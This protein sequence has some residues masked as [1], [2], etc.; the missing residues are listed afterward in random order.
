MTTRILL[1]ATCLLASACVNEFDPRCTLEQGPSLPG[2][3]FTA[4]NAKFEDVFRSRD[5]AGRWV[6]RVGN[7]GFNPA[8]D[9]YLPL[10]TTKNGTLTF[11]SEDTGE[12]DQT[13]AW[14]DSFSLPPQSTPG[15]DSTDS[16]GTAAITTEGSLP[17]DHAAGEATIEV[18]FDP[19]L[20]LA[21]NGGTTTLS[22]KL[23]VKVKAGGG[24][25]VGG[26]TDPGPTCS[27]LLDEV[28]ARD[29]SQVDGLPCDRVPFD[30]DEI[31]APGDT[32]GQCAFLDGDVAQ[33]V[34]L[35]WAVSCMG[36]F[37]DGDVKQQ[38]ID[39]A[40]QLLSDA[41]ALNGG[42][43]VGQVTCLFQDYPVCTL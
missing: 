25:S 15:A 23:R 26:G 3:T 34:N 43:Q 10:D 19:P 33:A 13:S 21:T 30:A 4:C 5:Q 14:V 22:G 29:S 42:G 17:T 39:E 11:K 37:S 7:A 38:R 36:L 6:I 41:C 24:A 31:Q 18:T 1:A 12:Q 35:C 8:M 28:A 2:Y 32:S 9:V 40:A 16:S 20:T 27:A